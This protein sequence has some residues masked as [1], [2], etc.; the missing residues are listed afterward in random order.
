MKKSTSEKKSGMF[1]TGV[2]IPESSR[3]KMVNLLNSELADLISLH[4]ATKQA[5][6][7]VKGAEFY[8]LHL[9]FD[10]LADSVDGFIDSTAERI[11]ALG[12]TAEG[13]IEA[14]CNNARIEAYPVG[15]STGREHLSA[16]IQRYTDLAN[17]TREAI[18][19]SGELGDM[20]TADLFT[21]ISRSLDKN[22]WFLEAHIQA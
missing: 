13:T 12:G 7:N 15:I 5:H 11:T 9:L 10:E 17:H 2:N 22:L 1:R 6:W 4:Y 19:R 16:L 3:A 18:D 21:E 14:A 8:Q 20:D